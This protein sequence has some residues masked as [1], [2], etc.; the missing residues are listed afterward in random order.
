M[1]EKGRSWFASTAAES[2][3]DTRAIDFHHSFIAAYLEEFLLYS[4]QG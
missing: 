1:R 4:R 2:S 3:E